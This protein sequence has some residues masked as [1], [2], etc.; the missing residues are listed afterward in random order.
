MGAGKGDIAMLWVTRKQPHVDRCA[1][2]WLIKRWI[3]REAKFGFVSKED[4]IP[5]GAIAFTLPEAEIRPVEGK[6]TTFD[7]LT[8]RY[9]VQDPFVLA[10]GKFIHDFEIDAGEQPKKV[11]FRETLGLCFILKGLEKTSRTDHETIEK[12]VNVLDAFYASVKDE[13]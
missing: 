6:T 3:D 13:P 2:A 4:A 1:S 11:K 9:H 12:A 8:E 10:I 5:S 7:A